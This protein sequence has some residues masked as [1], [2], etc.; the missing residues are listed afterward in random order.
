[1]NLHNSLLTSNNHQDDGDDDEMV[2]QMRDEDDQPRRALPDNILDL[3]GGFIS[4]RVP[5]EVSLACLFNSHIL[6]HM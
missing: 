6:N 5:I 4:A 2:S 1:M 3:P